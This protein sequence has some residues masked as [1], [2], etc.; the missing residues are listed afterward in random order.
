MEGLEQKLNELTDKLI[1][2][3][4]EQS[5]ALIKEFKSENETAI[6]EAVESGVK[7]VK[8]SIETIE[9]KVKSVQ[10]HTDKLDIKMQ[11]RKSEKS[12]KE[13]YFKSLIR[14]NIKEIKEVGGKKEF[15]LQ[16]KDMTL[17]NALTGDQP[18]DYNFDVV[19]RPAQMVNVE[20]L[21]T[22][23][24]IS[25]GTYTFS[26]STLA[27]GSVASQTEGNAKAQLEYDYAMIDANTDFIAGFAVYSKKMRNNLPFL[28]STLSLDLRN[29]YYRGENSAFQTILASEATTSTQS[30]AG[31]NKAE[32][33][34]QEIGTLAGLDFVSNGV[35]LTPADYFSILTIEKSTG[36]GYGLPLGWTFDGG[37]LRVMGSPVFMATWVPADKYYVGDWSR[38]RKIVTEGFSFAV[39]E[40]DSD[41]FRKNNITAR[42]EAQ[43]TLTVEQPTALRYGDFTTA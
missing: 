21:A 25:G 36:A 32:A 9:A 14:D 28:E 6:K 19:R 1:G 2:K 12:L 30:N 40:D 27:S 3:T 34:L 13:G 31:Q 42:V 23:I 5:E 22:S 38:V 43:V 11:E 33:I 29:D 35:V 17:A 18:R 4:K 26:R 16:V 15:S 20:D 10:E 41:N 24:Q 8:D 39:S 7:S 37:V